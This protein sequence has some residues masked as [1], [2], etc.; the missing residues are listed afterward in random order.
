MDY[1]KGKPITT[2]NIL[3][4]SGEGI[5][6]MKEKLSRLEPNKADW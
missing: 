5:Y 6:H 4:T 3:E 1:D 2:F